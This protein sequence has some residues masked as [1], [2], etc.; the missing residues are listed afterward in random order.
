[1]KKIMIAFAVLVPAFGVSAA[2]TYRVVATEAEKAGVWENAYTS[3][4]EAVKAAASAGDVV[5][6]KPGT[7]T[8]S[9]QLM[10]QADDVTLRS[11]D[12]TGHIDRE[13]TIVKGN[14]S[15]RLLYTNGKK[16]PVIDGFTFTNGVTSA[17]AGLYVAAG[18]GAYKI[19]NC[20]IA[21][22][23]ANGT[24]S[25]TGND[26]WGAGLYTV[27]NSGGLVSNCVFY[28]NRASKAKS[29]RCG[30]AI[31]ATGSDVTTVRDCTF[32]DNRASGVGPTGGA[33]AARGKILIY[34]SAFT[35]NTCTTDNGQSRGGHAHVGNN[36]VI[37][38]CTFS[39]EAQANYGTCI[40]S[41]LNAFI[42]NCVFAV[43]GSNHY[44]I[45]K[46][47]GS[48]QLVG[49]RFV[50]CTTANSVVY[51][52]ATPIL[53]NCLFAG[54]E[55]RFIAQSLN[56]PKIVI[57][58]CTVAN[59]TFVNSGKP[60][61]FNANAKAS[62]TNVVVNSIFEGSTLENYFDGTSIRY[63]LVTN[64]YTGTEA[65]FVGRGHDDYRL[66]ADSPCVDAGVALSWTA[67]GS[68]I[69]GR[70]RTIGIAPDIG[71][72]ERQ[73]HDP[74]V[75]AVRAVATEDDL[76]D[77]WSEAYVGIQPALDA[78][79]AGDEVWV[80][81]GSYAIAET[82][83]VPSRELTLR[84]VGA[85]VL[86]G[87][88][89]RRI[90]S[91][92]NSTGGYPKIVIDGFTFKDGNAGS[93]ADGCN[94]GGLFFRAGT[95]GAALP[96]GQVL[97]CV[98]TNCAAYHGG[99]LYLQYGG[100]ASN[101]QFFCNSAVKR[102]GGVCLDS[103]NVIEKFWESDGDSSWHV[104]RA[105]D[106]TAVANEAG[107]YGGGISS[108]G[109]ACQIVACTVVTNRSPRGGNVFTGRTGWT[110]RCRLTDGC[111]DSDSQAYGYNV[112]AGQDARV[113]DCVLSGG[114][115][116]YGSLCVDNKPGVRIE[117]CAVTNDAVAG[118]V[119]FCNGTGLSVRD[120]LIVG[121]YVYLYATSGEVEMRFENCTCDVEEFRL[122]TANAKNG[123][124]RATL[125]NTIV[126]GTVKGG[127][128]TAEAYGQY[129]SATNS[130]F[131]EDLVAS[132]L[133]EVMCVGCRVC[134]QPFESGY[135][136]R[137]SLADKGLLLDGMTGD[138]VDLAGRTRVF[139][140]KS[141]KTLADDPSA[142]P[143]LGCFERQDRGAGLCLILR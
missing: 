35:D 77:E 21:G 103:V 40:E 89:A 36:T 28:A 123:I 119:F 84:A 47:S 48:T 44:G 52:E 129:L 102:G 101:C 63:V 29:E 37:S 34:D 55:I 49:C 140:R 114:S 64:C 31:Y 135:L 66:K 93:A 45:I 51:T 3:L 88:N 78:A 5:L 68:D 125:V 32:T 116:T 106:C 13:H 133:S 90:M 141:G 11:D 43:Q 76:T 97:N 26:G 24:D 59:N 4:G 22:C 82:V 99:G 30:A 67:A 122:A 112:W 120:T 91:V 115:G 128:Q 58:H 107:D 65:G 57:E 61:W 15:I 92:D 60:F 124:T 19:L 127:S 81:E 62:T 75:F 111:W 132:R 9:A 56:A 96:C 71:C 87:G 105:V 143:D 50:G 38:G 85:V 138:S 39:G 46:A 25:A 108:G 33:V 139:S 83:V 118:N 18:A 54:S 121:K 6:V 23:T 130:C 42:S 95:S 134:A 16:R 104:P 86:D 110:D 117:R 69:V 73:A 109:L 94:G 53:R 20:T 100:V 7:Y 80:R 14:G 10:L 70:P 1:M 17:G 74:D 98:F 27:D 137:K 2:T 131:T 72:Y 8:L 126:S 41:S 136:P 142:L 12:G 113:S 79:E